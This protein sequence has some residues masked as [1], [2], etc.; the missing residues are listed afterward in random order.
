MREILAAALFSAVALVGRADDFPAKKFSSFTWVVDYEPFWSP[1]GKQIV[2]VSS[3]HGGMK[4]HVMNA[5]SISHGSDMRQITF[6]NDEDDAPAWSPDGKQIAFISVRNDVSQLCVMNA[7]GANPRQL[8]HGKA[9]NIH[10]VWSPDSQR[11][12]FNTTQFAGATAA[13][14]REVPSDNKVIGEQIDK[15]MDLATIRPDGSDSKRLTTGG[16]YT[17][18]SFS[19]DGKSILH[20]RVD[21]PKSQIWIMNADGSGD[22]NI[23][24]EGTLDGWP[25]WSNDGQRVVFSRRVNDR[26]QLFVMNRDGSGLMQLTDAAGEFV[27]PRW[28]PDGTRIMCARRLADMNIIIFPAPKFA[29]STAR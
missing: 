1:D 10:P 9:E 26:F 16:G 2:L 17:Y 24:G 5:D 23:S 3:R 22:H 4:V 27:N 8:T 12:L 25:A 29:P 28:S 14:G 18:A 20:R 15:K 7:D 19:P 11:I 13:D 21:G 6:G